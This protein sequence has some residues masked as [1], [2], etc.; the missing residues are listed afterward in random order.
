M[1]HNEN[2]ESEKPSSL[3]VGQSLAL[4]KMLEETIEP[5]VK[6]IVCRVMKPMVIS[7]VQQ[8][9]EPVAE[10][11]FRRVIGV[12]SDFYRQFNFEVKEE[13]QSVE[14][15]VLAGGSRNDVMKERSLHLMFLDEVSGPVQTSTELK[16]IKGDPLE[17]ALFDATEHIVNC[18]PESSAKVEIVLIDNSGHDDENNMTHEN[19]ERRIIKAGDKK[20]PYLAGSVYICLEKGVGNLIGLKLGHGKD[21]TNFC[22]CRLGVRLV[23]NFRGIVVQEAWTEPFKVIDKRGKQYVK[24][25]PPLPTSEVWRLEKIA[26][27]GEPCNRLNEKNIKTVQDFLFWHHINPEGLQQEILQ[28]GDGTW[29][30]I[31]AHAC[32]CTIDEKKMYLH[33]SPTEPQMSVIYDA[34]GKPKGV[35]DE[36]HFVTIDNLS[37]DKK[38]RAHKLLRSVLTEPSFGERYNTSFNEEDSHLQQ[39]PYNSPDINASTNCSIQQCSNCNDLT[40]FGNINGHQTTG[41]GSSS[42]SFIPDNISD[43]GP[44]DTL[45]SR[46]TG[47]LHA[48]PS[49]LFPDPDNIDGDTPT[50]LVLNSSYSSF[51]FFVLVS[52]DYENHEN[53]CVPTSPTLLEKHKQA[54][55]QELMPSACRKNLG[56]DLQQQLTGLDT[57]VDS[58][59]SLNCPGARCQNAGHSNAPVG[60]TDQWC[61]SDDDSCGMPNHDRQPA[62]PSPDPMSYY[63]SN[64]YFKHEMHSSTNESNVGDE[65]GATA[66]P[67]V[68]TTSNPLNWWYVLFHIFKWRLVSKR[69]M[70]SLNHIPKRKKQKVG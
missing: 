7:I 32:N 29:K 24:H 45:G 37:A 58:S 47:E 68:V 54:D 57:H 25:N 67:Q 20:K 34:V 60:E 63:D 6:N 4:R 38:D 33:K 62:S 55:A 16:G 10:D 39:H 69:I 64:D 9:I 18:G 61:F 21:W 19:F 12:V 46:G 36:S 66:E 65:S 28:V 51:R 50:Y 40:R 53:H 3:D 15:K 22:N 1:E 30:A 70:V 26:R 48:P 52:S 43:S 42:Q 59:D 27:K 11:L 49:G 35:I 23:Q 44:S 2:G 8:V 5:M 56:K 31:V 41:S 14:K 17:V 13:M